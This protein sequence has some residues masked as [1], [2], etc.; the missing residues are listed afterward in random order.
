MAAGRAAPLFENRDDARNTKLTAIHPAATTTPM[1]GNAPHVKA[2][3]LLS[4]VGADLVS[5]A[6]IFNPW[7][8]VT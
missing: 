4:R 5:V 8:G 7:I 1:V 2:R 3:L 6:A